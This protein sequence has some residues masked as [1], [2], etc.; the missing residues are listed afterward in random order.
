MSPAGRPPAVRSRNRGAARVASGHPWVYRDDVAD[1]GGARHGD[2]V[3]VEGPGGSPAGWAFWSVRSKI[4]LR[5]VAP[6]GRVDP[7]DAEFWRCRIHEAASLR[8]APA[9]CAER[10]V[11]AE[12]DGVPGFVADRYGAHLVVQALVAAVEPILDVLVDALC[13][14]RTIESVLARNDPSV[15]ALEGLPRETAQLRGTTPRRIPV[16]EGEIVY[17][18]DPWEGQ[19]TGAFLDQA[20]N[21]IRA[22]EL[23]RGR[24]LDAFAYHA[25]FGLHA[26][27]RATE[28]VVVDSSRGAIARG[29]ELA[30]RNG[31]G[32]L[33]FVVAN[34]FD[35]LRERVRAE[36]RFDVVLLDPPAFA[37]SR[38]DLPQAR[39]GYRDVNLHA[40]RLLD[41]GGILVTSSCSYNLAEE[42]FLDVLAEAASEAG[43]A[44][45]VLER[46]GQAADHPVRLG[47]PE[48]RYL[49][50]VILRRRGNGG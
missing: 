5:V 26:G 2:V 35:D 16:R 11:F 25:A 31:I 18:A 45:T 12:A 50:C 41:P 10:L 47:F 6:A 39:R 13:E 30:A 43:A 14:T 48:S 33:R 34:V 46:R 40:M 38:R 27:R 4:A 20:A 32:T 37:K 15:R 22:G 44:F 29:E 17:D 19:K 36:E 3:R 28:V 21:R 24:V 23:A 1:D 9:S 8:A 49:K 7:P 42:E